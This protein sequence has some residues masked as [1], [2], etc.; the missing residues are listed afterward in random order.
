MAT[1]RP[2]PNRREAD[3][4]G[5]RQS[6]GL[7]QKEHEVMLDVR[8]DAAMICDGTGNP[9]Y[10]GDI[11]VR[12]RRI[13]TLGVVKERGRKKIIGSGLV[14]CPGFVDVHTHADHIVERPTADNMLRQ[15]VT[16]VVSGN[17]GGSGFPIKDTL[18]RV[19]A[20]RPAINYATLL[21]HATIRRRVMGMAGRKPT[22][23]ELSEMCR[24]AEQAMR[25][26]AVGMSTG[27]F[28]VPGAYAKL[29][30]FVEISKAIAAHGGVYA[31]H[32][33]SAGGKMF[34]AIREA[35]TIGKRAGISIEIS[36][37]KVLHKRGRT[38]K[39][40]VDEAIAVVARYREDGIDVTYDLHPYPA[41]F[42]SLAAVA[43]P[44]WV[45]TDGK[46]KERLRNA[47]IRKRIRGDVASNIAWI[48]GADRITIARFAPDTSAEGKSLADAARRRRRD[49]VAT[50]MDMIVEGSPSC[51]F[52]ALRPADVSK[53]ICSA[54]AMIASDGGI[55]PTRTGVVHPRNYGT[56][57]RVLREYVRESKLM[58]LEEA[59]RKMTSL[60]A[61]KFGIRDRGVLAVGMKADV[62]L[63]DPKTVGEKAT[64][65]NPHAF[66][67][68]IKHV[69]VNGSVAWNGRSISRRRAGE[70]IRHCS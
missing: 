6:R 1:M 10:R 30:E 23:K 17:C 18:D 45:S 54:N 21:G 37:L 56:F 31:T 8:I 13:A 26:G 47:S 52:H 44:P 46:L 24:L 62:V 27:L 19:E 33:R 11:G 69:I 65:D 68:G 9:W 29:D 14:V 28:Y 22:R 7:S 40:R 15:G 66:P 2:R 51:V 4:G 16:T 49:P 59:V 38:R 67:V 55:V 42:T 12:D 70:S 34:D 57:P 39:S 61:R 36:H 3:S 48:G 32:K 50:A 25:E 43:I 35:A 20:A 58:S 41:T 5:D 64:F 63:F 53:I 60:P